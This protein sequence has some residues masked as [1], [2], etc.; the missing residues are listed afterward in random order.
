MDERSER[1]AKRFEVPILVA[2][3]L[4]IPVILVE[5]SSVGQ[6]WDGIASVLNWA[7]WLAFLAEVVVM[8]A[9]VPDRWR[10]LRQHPL[11]VIVVV[12]TP[13]FLP[14][15]LQSIRVLRLLRLVRLLRLAQVVRRLFTFDGLRYAA[16][17]ALMTL[18]GGG[19]AFAS[20]EKEPT[21]WDGIWWAA[22]TMTT[23]GYGDVPVTTDAG[24]VIGLIVMVV[25]IGFGTLVIG[26]ISERFV[27][28]QIELEVE[29]AEQ[30]TVE[31]VEEF[32]IEVLQELR[33]MSTRLQQLEAALER[34]R[35][36]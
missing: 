29:H 31:A 3:L 26:A 33:A 32:E 35:G 36:G 7:I 12:L 22:T 34:R 9:V 5:E 6:P 23:V 24:R 27:T 17:L 25:G 20:V 2:A 11:E 16:L 10:W 14:A 1:I 15:S 18:I 30:E 28:P 13:P 19:T 4:V 8:L 21:A